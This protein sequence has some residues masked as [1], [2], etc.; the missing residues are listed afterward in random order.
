MMLRLL[1]MMIWM[2]LMIW[3]GQVTAALRFC[4]PW[5]LGS[6]PGYPWEAAPAP[7]PP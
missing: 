7:K 1:W 4:F 3:I 5:P 2:I 6:L